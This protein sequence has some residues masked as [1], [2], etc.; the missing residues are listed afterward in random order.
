MTT[1]TNKNTKGANWQQQKLTKSSITLRLRTDLGRSVWVTAATQLI[2]LKTIFTMV[3]TCIWMGLFFTSLSIWIWKGPGTPSARPYPKA[4]QV[5]PS[6]SP[7]PHDIET[8]NCWYKT[9]T[10]ILILI[11]NNLSTS[12]EKAHPYTIYINP[13]IYHLF[14]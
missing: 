2:W 5:T 7:F 8:E 10:C 1:Y 3:S 13:E 6:P 9:S 14:L 12:Y 4:W 11:Y